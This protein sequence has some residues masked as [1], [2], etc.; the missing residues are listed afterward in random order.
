MTQMQIPRRVLEDVFVTEG[1]PEETY[2][3]PPNFN[4]ILLDIRH[5]GK[6]VVLEGPSGTGK[7]CT[8]KKVLERI[9]R[10]SD[11]MYLSARKSEDV[12]LIQELADRPSPGVFIIDDFHRLGPRHQE[13]LSDIAKLAAEEGEPQKHPKLVLIGINQVGTALIQFSPD[14]AKRCGIHR[15]QPA[16]LEQTTRLVEKGC[17]ALNIKFDH[18]SLFFQESRGDYW[19]TQRLCSAACSLDNIIETQPEI[20]TLSADFDRVRKS[21]IEHLEAA[22]YEPVKEFCRGRRFRP[23]NDPYYRILR[24]IATK[25]ELTSSVDLVELANANPEIAGSINNVKDVRLSVLLNEKPRAGQYFYFNRETARLSI[26]DPAV[27]YFLRNLD[28]EKVRSDCGFRDAGQAS[29]PIDIALSFA[30]ENRELAKLIANRL[31]ELDVSVYFD[32]DYENL[33]LGKQ[34][35]DEFE[36]AFSKQSRYVVCLLDVLHRKKIWPTF[37][38]D[39][40]LP[41]V[42]QAQVIP[43]YLDDTLFPGI[44]NDLYG[45]EFKFSLSSEDWRSLVDEKIILRLIDRI[46]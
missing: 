9:G 42:K 43:I 32:E 40:F 24:F 33:I 35:S 18:N 41:R 19:L 11:W 39:V 16:T 6:P 7:T 21:I 28:W 10:S 4:Q 1:V 37:E 12:E 30:G 14:V 13:K 25:P 45:I 34:L 8:V 36:R 17:A 2:V 20:R 31:R 26:E 44:P 38:R 27:F 5:V 46:G 29:Q 15:V 3:D 23:S 22:Y